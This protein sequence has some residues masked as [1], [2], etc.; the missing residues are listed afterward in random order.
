MAAPHQSPVSS[1]QGFFLATCQILNQDQ[2]KSFQ[3]LAVVLKN[4]PKKFM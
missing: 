2:E 4:K 1:I 3:H